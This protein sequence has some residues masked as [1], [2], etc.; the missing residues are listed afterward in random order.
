M[1]IM[2]FLCTSVYVQLCQQIRKHR[3][4]TINIGTVIVIT[5]QPV[6]Q[7]RAYWTNV[8]Q[9]TSNYINT[10]TEVPG[11]GYSNPQPQIMCTPDA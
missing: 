3:P 8:N 2:T 6:N 4:T 7:S 9:I 1:T 11:T 10:V 5:R